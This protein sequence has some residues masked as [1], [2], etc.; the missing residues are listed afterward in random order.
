MTQPPT[1]LRYTPQHEWVRATGTLARI[2]V[3]AHATENLGD[4]VYVSLPTVGAKV[5]AG[6]ACAEL[7][8][9]K[10][11]SDVFAP[12]G[13]VIAAV[14]EAVSDA[15]E[16]INADPYETGWLF[17]VEMGEAGVPDTLLTPQAYSELV[18]GAES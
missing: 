1:D 4:I 7:E 15:P 2:G 18:D 10:S 13:G 9:T 5:S 6:D 16:T 8:S 11:V 14:N 17:D 3:T 12:V